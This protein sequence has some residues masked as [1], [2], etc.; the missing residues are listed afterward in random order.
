MLCL[1][2]GGSL[3]LGE[4]EATCVQ[5]QKNLSLIPESVFSANEFAPGWKL[6]VV[7]VI[8]LKMFKS[9]GFAALFSSCCQESHGP[10]PALCFLRQNGSERSEVEGSGGRLLNT[11]QTTARGSSSGCY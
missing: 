7:V 3:L 5:L 11:K 8:A 6:V 2:T 1:P 10:F 4:M 9:Q